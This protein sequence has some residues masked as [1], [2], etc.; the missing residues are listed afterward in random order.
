L[1]IEVR[2]PGQT[3][4]ELGRPLAGEDQV[5]VGIDEPGHHCTS[6]AVIVRKFPITGREIGF[7]PDPGNLAVSNRHGGML[8]ETELTGSTGIVGHQLAYPCQQ[9]VPGSRARRR[10]GDISGQLD[11]FVADTDPVR[12]ADDPTNLILAPATEGTS[13]QPS[14]GARLYRRLPN[15]G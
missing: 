1:D 15:H 12:A 2:G 11:A 13:Q 3:R 10:K 7:E 4:R 5:S 9:E 6:F 14:H 8:D